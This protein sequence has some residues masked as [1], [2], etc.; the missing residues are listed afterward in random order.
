MARIREH[1]NGPPVSRAILVVCLVLASFST[2]PVD[3]VAA[4]GATREAWFTGVER[5]GDSIVRVSNGTASIW[6]SGSHRINVTFTARTDGVK[7]TVC[8]HT[9]EGFEE[10]RPINRCS[11]VETV[12]N[13]STIRESFGVPNRN[14]TS[15]RLILTIRRTFGDER[16]ID[17]RILRY[18][19]I[20][21][22]GDVD[23][24]G[25]TNAE[26]VAETRWDL[27]FTRADTD[28]DGLDDRL[29]VRE[30]ATDPTKADTDG[31]GHADKSEI[32]ETDA[33]D[34]TDY[35]GSA[36]SRPVENGT[37][38][39]DDGTTADA[40]VLVFVGLIGASGVGAAVIW[41]F[42]VPPTVG[43]DGAVESAAGADPPHPGEG[44]PYPAPPPTHEPRD[45]VAELLLTD[46]DRVYDL[47]RRHG[48]RMK[49]ATI[50]RETDWSKSKVSRLLS[51]MEERG[52]INKLRVGRGNVIYFDG[53]EPAAARSPFDGE[54]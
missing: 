22:D 15:G 31:D 9:P 3:A 11:I 4:D 42:G 2:V 51:R 47:V 54:E 17:R 50:V 8:L 52:D 25:L 45:D 12:T 20:E 27:N 39:G 43:A 32:G 37:A 30:Y 36:T 33:T 49:Q 14:A 16:P 23:G 53:A 10:G 40:L 19:V 21:K 28:G 7:Y 13:G 44:S 46:E 35:P 5:S 41:R 38:P 1:V 48:G 24:D 34:P 6:R 29:E 18:R 26:E